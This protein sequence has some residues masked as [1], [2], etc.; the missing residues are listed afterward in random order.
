MATCGN[1][2]NLLCRWKKE[3]TEIYSVEV[4]ALKLE[5]KRLQKENKRLEME[6]EILKKAAAFFMK[7]SQN[8]I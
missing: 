1:K 8:E 5:L 6:R 7:E 4:D 2:Y 3:L